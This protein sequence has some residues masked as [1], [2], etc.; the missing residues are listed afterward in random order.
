MQKSKSTVLSTN[1]LYYAVASYVLFA[2]P[3]GLM[4]I[5]ES[6]RARQAAETET[7]RKRA[8]KVLIISIIGIAP[9]AIDFVIGL[10]GSGAVYGALFNSWLVTIVL[11]IS[12]FV[13]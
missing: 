8:R 2:A 7:E 1:A 11:I 6:Q 3:L 13:G 9:P 12:K 10:F 4:A 5:I